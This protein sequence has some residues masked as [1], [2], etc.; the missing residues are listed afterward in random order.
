MGEYSCSAKCKNGGASY[1]AGEGIA[2][3]DNVI[4]NT[5]PGEIYTGG[6]NI[7]ISSENAINLNGFKQVDGSDWGAYIDENNKAT[8][9]LIISVK[10]PSLTSYPC[11]HFIGKGMTCSGFTIG[12]Q[13]LE[14]KFVFYEIRS[15]VNRT[16][17]LVSVR[18]IEYN[19]SEGSISVSSNTISIDKR[20][21]IKLFYRE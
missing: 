5:A 2:I 14:T 8:T 18:A 12:A 13:S 19:I 4:T 16:T 1:T 9:D 6:S 17:N 20:Y 15:N 10:Y 11:Y 7:S 21:D 3:E